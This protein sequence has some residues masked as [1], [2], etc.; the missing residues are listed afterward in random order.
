MYGL[1]PDQYSMWE[2][3]RAAVSLLLLVIIGLVV[4]LHVDDDTL[5]HC[6]A[7]CMDNIPAIDG[8][9]LRSSDGVAFDESHRMFNPAVAAEPCVVAE[10]AN[11]NDVSK[12]LK[13]ASEHD[14]TVR[15]RATGVGF[16]GY[17][18]CAGDRCLVISLVKMNGLTLGGNVARVGG[19]I[20]NDKFL[21]ELAKSDMKVVTGTCGVVGFAGLSLGGGLSTQMR[22]H[23][24]ATDNIVGMQI[25]VADG[26]VLNA[27]NV[28]HP[29]L[30]WALRGGGNNNYGVVTRFDVRV[31]PTG[32]KQYQ[33]REIIVPRERAVEGFLEWQ[34][35]KAN[36]PPTAF[37]QLSMNTGAGA[38]QTNFDI[39]IT[40]TGTNAQ[41]QAVVDDFKLAGATVDTDSNPSCTGID[42]T[43]IEAVG[44][45]EDC[46]FNSGSPGARS[47]MAFADLNASDA[48]ALFA[49]FETIHTSPCRYQAAD[50]LFDGMGGKVAEPAVDYNAFPHR[51]ALYSLQYNVYWSRM[52]QNPANILACTNWINDVHAGNHGL[53]NLEYRNYIGVG[54]QGD[55]D[56]HYGANYARLQEI[57]TVYD[58]NNLFR[59]PIGVLPT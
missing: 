33:V 38:L 51:K 13:F 5:G 16:A 58:P 14:Y 36:L 8:T 31:Y 40:L 53:S 47:R 56:S 1:S 17:S 9:L 44:C 26:R 42:M 4:S 54:S 20:T 10:V 41:M 30:Y 52:S 27:D 3:W 29:D 21:R 43:W 50:I 25:V 48:T 2:W 32:G 37:T 34:R 35:W 57:K 11:A 55:Q 6:Q 7:R 22:E 19:G 46:G 15:T 45:Y 12:L 49:A 59:Y 24:L 28:T 18:T 39:A 23:G